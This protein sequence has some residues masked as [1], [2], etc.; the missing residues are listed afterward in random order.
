MVGGSSASAKKA[1]LV[2][3]TWEGGWWGEQDGWTRLGV[4]EQTLQQTRQQRN[5]ESMHAG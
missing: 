3:G 1:P 5:V 4:A 2:V